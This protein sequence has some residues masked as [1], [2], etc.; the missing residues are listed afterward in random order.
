MMA[1]FRIRRVDATNPRVWAQLVLMDSLCFGHDAPP[2]TDNSGVWWI[3]SHDGAPAG[4]AAIK[5]SM[6]NPEDGG[7]MHRAGV[8]SE[9][10]GNGLQKTLIKRRL[11]Y[12]KSQGWDWVVTD[13]NNNPASGNSLISCGFKMFSPS[14][15]WSFVSA[16]Y[17]RKYL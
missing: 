17:W 8:L 6:S 1:K 5:P 9:F 7:Y 3:A 16:N 13:T 4:Y 12:A 15:P 11:S 10:R 14:N 2:L